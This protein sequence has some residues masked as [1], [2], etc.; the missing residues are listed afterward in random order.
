MN[1]D[2]IQVFGDKYILEDGA[3]V[4]IENVDVNQVVSEFSAPDILDALD[5]ADVVEWLAERE[6]ERIEDYE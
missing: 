2:N 5:Y 4:Y 1:Q 6:K 3:G